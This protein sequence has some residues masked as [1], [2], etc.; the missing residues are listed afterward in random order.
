MFAL[1][2]FLKSL[3]IFVI[4]Y[5]VVTT[6]KKYYVPSGSKQ[7]QLPQLDLEAEVGVV[8]QAFEATPQR[9]ESPAV[10][11]TEKPLDPVPSGEAIVQT[12][13]NI[14]TDPIEIVGDG[15]KMSYRGQ[16][17]P[18]QRQLIVKNSEQALELQKKFDVISIQDIIR[19]QDGSD[20]FLVYRAL[21]KDDFLDY[22]VFW[23]NQTPFRLSRPEVSSDPSRESIKPTKVYK[24]VEFIKDVTYPTS[25]SG[26]IRER[27]GAFQSRNTT[28]GPMAIDSK[29]V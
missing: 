26:F 27:E 13:D 5:L 24:D 17:L 9:D 15:L 2:C 20:V 14:P 16:T 4:F 7:P 21:S 3:F 25:L 22:F 11:E 23:N 29:R 6:Y 28:T 8:E 12:P 10:V 1:D 18:G 19:F